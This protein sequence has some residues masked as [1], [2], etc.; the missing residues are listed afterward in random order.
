MAASS[1]KTPRARPDGFR[2]DHAEAFWIRLARPLL[3]QGVTPCYLFS[4]E[5]IAE[6]LTRLDEAFKGI[7][8]THWLSVK[9]Q[10]L[11][12]LLSWWLSR[13][14]PIEV[15]SELE[16]Q[17][18]LR[19]CCPADRLLVN[20]P[21]K[22]RWL[23]RHPLPGLNVNFDSVAE[24]SALGT[25]AARCRWRIGVRLN[26][27]C[28]FDTDAPDFATQFGMTES[29]LAKALP[30]LKRKRL[31][32]EVAHF[33]LRTN[34]ASHTDYLGGIDESL[35]ILGRHGMT[36]PVLDIGGGFPAPDVTV[37]RGAR[38]DASFSLRSLAE[39]LR[40]TRRRWPFI[41]EFW[42]ENG[43]WISGRSGALLVRILD[44]KERGA[45]RN[46]ICDSGRTMNSLVSVWENH[47]L[48]TLPQ[49]SGPERM[50]TVNGPTCMAY[51]KLARRP[52]PASLR[53]GDHLLWLDAGA[54]HIPW[55]TR[56]SHGLCG[57]Y[58]HDGATL[59]QVRA[60]ES[61]E[62]WF[63]QWSR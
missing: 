15:V 48:L 54:Y 53:P 9:T 44:A 36:P 14:R 41:R 25:L 5:P 10:P 50:T 45:H 39:G 20:G 47:R 32:V 6:A 19:M 57:I 62:Q 8:V 51:D 1:S 22:H 23:H 52:L 21:A 61:F 30:L 29:E 4:C 63:S 38:L 58:W 33:H 49:R 59:S 37:R 17:L 46:L 56:F 35:G 18:A 55:E 34:L 13:G 43:R 12:Q 31:T 3:R 7:P 24:V 42:M 11:P 26:T 16:L 40:T 2:P 28:E 60:P 27:R